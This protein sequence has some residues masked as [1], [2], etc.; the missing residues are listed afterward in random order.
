MDPGRPLFKYCKA[1]PKSRPLSS[2]RKPIKPNLNFWCN[3]KS[4]LANV[5]DAKS[6]ELSAMRVLMRILRF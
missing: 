4:Q 1:L 5:A 3:F 6:S 2:V